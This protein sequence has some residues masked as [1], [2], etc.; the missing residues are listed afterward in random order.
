MTC[1]RALAGA[2]APR[3]S[4]GGLRRRAT[5]TPEE[6]PWTA[7]DIPAAAKERH[8]HGLTS[9]T[10]S[11]IMLFAFFKLLFYYRNISMNGNGL[12]LFQ[13]LQNSL[14]RQRHVGSPSTS[15]PQGTGLRRW[16]SQRE[17]R[18]TEPARLAGG[19]TAPENKTGA[20]REV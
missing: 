16:K 14:Y 17:T 9:H 18:F 1:L 19:H 6:V 10:P 8:G 20:A 12:G 13:S 15:C 7:P 5:Q 11:F 2:W 4:P 3:R